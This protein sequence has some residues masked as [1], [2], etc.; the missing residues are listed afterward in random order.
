MRE[1]PDPV[2]KSDPAQA[3]NWRLLVFGVIGLCAL[4]VV[5]YPPWAVNRRS[6]G[7]AVPGGPPVEA[8]EKT[9]S[10]VLAAHDLRWQLVQDRDFAGRVL[11]VRVPSD[12]PVSSLHLAIQEGIH[13]IGARMLGAESEPVSGRL[14]VHVGWPDSC[15]LKIRLIPARELRRQ[16][17]RIAILLDDFGDRWDAFTAAF[18]ELP[19]P[20][21]ISVIPGLSQSRR[22]YQEARARGCETLIHLPMQ[23]VGQDGSRNPKM[24]HQSMT[25]DQIRVFMAEVFS[26]APDAA[27]VNNHMGSL[28]TRDRRLMGVVLDEI[29]KRGLFF[30]DSRTTPES[31]AYSVAREMGLPCTRRDVFLDNTRTREA[32]EREMN[33]L[34]AIAEEKGEALGIGHCNQATLEALRSAMPRLMNAGFRFVRVSELVR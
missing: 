25:H 8:I 16:R 20:V 10:E 18:L 33:R 17:G 21:S 7:P 23:P 28:V 32:V 3:M 26:Q 31:V 19:A 1:S 13:R 34:A 30:V 5:L 12:L 14:M 2:R 24:I 4:V 9:V 22:V 11:S 15:L 27:G 29:N 6:A